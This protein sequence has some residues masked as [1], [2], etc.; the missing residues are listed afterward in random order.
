[1]IRLTLYAVAVFFSFSLLVSCGEEEQLAK[2]DTSLVPWSNGAGGLFSMQNSKREAGFEYISL[3]PWQ[4]LTA[5]IDKLTEKRF[6]DNLN[7]DATTSE[8]YDIKSFKINTYDVTTDYINHCIAENAKKQKI[9]IIKND[10]GEAVWDDQTKSNKLISA[11]YLP[12]T[13]NLKEE[14]KN[15]VNNDLKS[16]AGVFDLDKVFDD[17]LKNTPD[18]VVL[19]TDLVGSVAE[20][21][22][23]I[24]VDICIGEIAPKKTVLKK[25]KDDFTWTSQLNEHRGETQK[26]V[27]E[28]LKNLITDV[29]I[30]ENIENKVLY[31]YYIAD[32]TNFFLS[33]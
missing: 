28:S 1:M 11:A 29:S 32:N 19:R 8:L 15:T 24:R 20:L 5:Y 22:K 7:I 30:K 4:T 16:I 6:F 25:F 31:S 18:D 17:R 26:C 2:G 13:S 9:N 21:P 27:S 3:Q 33:E 12:N 23:M 14:F 10:K